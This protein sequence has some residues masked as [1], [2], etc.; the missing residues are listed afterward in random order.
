LLDHRLEVH[1]SGNE[2]FHESQTA[3]MHDDTNSDMR[4]L[5]QQNRLAMPV[6]GRLFLVQS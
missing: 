2:K 6:V 4:V 1:I 3:F 5:R